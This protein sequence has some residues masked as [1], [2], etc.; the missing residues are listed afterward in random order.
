M[1]ASEFN[2]KD[3]IVRGSDS[4]AQDTYGVVLAKNGITDMTVLK[5]LVLLNDLEK[6]KDENGVEIIK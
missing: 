1:N 2:V 4:K 5:E 3:D 6:N